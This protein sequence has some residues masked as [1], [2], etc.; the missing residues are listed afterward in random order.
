MSATTSACGTVGPAPP[1]AART[2]SEGANRRLEDDD[3]IVLDKRQDLSVPLDVRE[4]AARYSNRSRSSAR[5][6][7][8]GDG[9]ERDRSYTSYWS[10]SERMRARSA[11]KGTVG[12]ATGT[13]YWAGSWLHDP[14]GGRAR[15]LVWTNASI[16]KEN[17][18][19]DR[20]GRTHRRLSS[21]GAV[22]GSHCRSAARNGK[23]NQPDPSAG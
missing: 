22:A 19:N 3:L 7:S 1:G 23:S 20:A 5:A 13:E 14:R 16:Q 8:G 12:A 18:W 21:G 10:S 4:V 11:V 17:P 2:T 15:S 9:R 6:A